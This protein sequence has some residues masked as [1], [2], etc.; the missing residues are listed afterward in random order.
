MTGP[1]KAHDAL[2]HIDAVT[3]NVG[4]AIDITQEF[5]R[6]KIDADANR[7]IALRADIDIFL[8]GIFGQTEVRIRALQEIA[9]MHADKK[10]VFRIA[11]KAHRCAIAGVEN[12]ALLKRDVLQRVGKQRREP[13]F[14]H[15]LLRDR[16]F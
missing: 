15:N 7:Q 8:R 16:F 9:H 1:R 10:G 11:Q 6:A 4:M 5:D 13:I 12:D 2:G 3:H 14:Q